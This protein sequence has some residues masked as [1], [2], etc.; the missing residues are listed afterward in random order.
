MKVV[1]TGPVHSGKTS[2]LKKIVHEL[3]AS[4]MNIEG[5]LS[6]AVQQNREFTGYDLFSIREKMTLPFLRKTGQKEWMRVGPYF[7]L[8]KGLRE[9]N[10]IILNPEP[11]DVLIVDEIGPL[12]LAGQGLWPAF[13]QAVQDSRFSILCV[14][15]KTIISDFLKSIPATQ[16]IVFNIDDENIFPRLLDSLLSLQNSHF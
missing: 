8:P 14:A 9:A 5:F 15:R 10:R 1:L 4:G 2:L 6:I 3:E 7:F 13:T 11:K 12:E 16:W